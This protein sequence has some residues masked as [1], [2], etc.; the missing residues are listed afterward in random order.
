MKSGDTVT[1]VDHNGQTRIGIL[2]KPSDHSDQ[3]WWIR[4]EPSNSP[5]DG[6]LRLVQVDD[7]LEGK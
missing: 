6:V 1:F 7:I 5:I 4:V 2:D 3:R